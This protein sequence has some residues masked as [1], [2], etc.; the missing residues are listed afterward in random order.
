MDQG[1][2]EVVEAL[3]EKYSRLFMDG[4]IEVVDTLENQFKY[5]SS[6][7]VDPD[8]DWFEYWQK[9]R[10]FYPKLYTAAMVLN[11]IK[12]SSCSCERVFS[13]AA[14]LVTKKPSR[15]EPSKVDQLICLAKNQDLFTNELE[16]VS[17]G[18]RGSVLSTL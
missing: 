11:T 17:K 4:D 7:I 15:L 16:K 6:D 12:V 3:H 1:F 14:L 5:Y 9:R 2:Y 8:V 13:K 18:W 10:C